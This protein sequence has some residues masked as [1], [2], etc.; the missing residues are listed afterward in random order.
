MLVELCRMEGSKH[1]ALISSQL[2]DIAIRV[3]SVREFTVGQMALLLENAH[4]LLGPAASNSSIAEVLI[5]A[6]WICGEFSHFLP[7]P[8]KTVEAVAK[9]RL[10]CLPGHIQAVLV[11]NLVKLLIRITSLAEEEDDTQLIKE[12]V[13]LLEERLES[14]TFSSDLEVQERAMFALQ[15]VKLLNEKHA[16]GEKLGDELEGLIAGEL[17]PVAAKAQKKV[18][19]PDGLDLDAWINSPPSESEPDEDD[20]FLSTN[21]FIKTEES[22]IV[23]DNCGPSDKDL[24]QKRIDRK[25]EQANNPYYMKVSSN[26]SSGQSSPKTGMADI[27]DIPVES[28]ELDVPLNI[29]GMT[30]WSKYEVVGSS[31]SGKKK[32]RVKKSKKGKRKGAVEESSSDNEA[33]AALVINK[34]D[35]EMPEGATLSDDDDND[36]RPLDDPHRALDIDLDSPLSPNEVLPTIQHHRTVANESQ[37]T[38][39]PKEKVKKTKNAKKKRSSKHKED[40]ANGE[41][42]TKSKKSKREKTTKGKKKS[43]KESSKVADMIEIDVASHDK[44]EYEFPPEDSSNSPLSLW[45]LAGDGHVQMEWTSKAMAS[46]IQIVSIRISLTHGDDVKVS[47]LELPDTDGLQLVRTNPASDDIKLEGRL[48]QLEA[49][50]KD[51]TVPHSMRGTL[52]YALVG[53]ISIL[54]NIFSFESIW[55]PLQLMCLLVFIIFCYQC[56]SFK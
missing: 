16:A 22:S 30:S 27:S 55:Y 38:E 5:A 32:H 33:P 18:P 13:S 15:L 21:L 2:M 37:P 24:Q 47:H 23:A 52:H 56:S 39:V 41:T 12:V 35:G 53:N 20:N 50:V 11:H 49:E 4:V 34:C 10:S 9:S 19:L 17:N 3:G 25:R 51:V 8:Q 28:I 1:G 43:R 40:I 46:S 6:S 31:R 48:L 45:P 42:K 26:K 29:P 44:A 54:A 7:N 36:S 14:W